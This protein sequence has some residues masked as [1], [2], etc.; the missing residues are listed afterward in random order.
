MVELG[1]ALCGPRL[2]TKRR[3][4]GGRQPTDLRVYLDFILTPGECAAHPLS[5]R[6]IR[7]AVACSGKAV[8]SETR[9]ATPV[10]V[11]AAAAQLESFTRCWFVRRASDKGGW[12]DEHDSNTKLPSRFY[13]CTD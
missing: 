5:P 12:R 8:R 2:G 1:A 3:N 13:C 6:Q 10:V 11:S 9:G 4:M 7:L